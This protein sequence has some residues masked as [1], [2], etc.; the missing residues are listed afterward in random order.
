MAS[1]IDLDVAG[2]TDTY[3]SGFTV[4]QVAKKYSV[5]F[6]TAYCRLKDNNVVMRHNYC[7]NGTAMQFYSDRNW[8]WNEYIEKEKS[9]QCIGNELQCSHVTIRNWLLRFGIPLR[10]Q[11]NANH[12]SR[13]NILELSQRLTEMLEGELLGDGYLAIKTGRRSACYVHGTKHQEYLWW[14]SDEFASEGLE[15]SGRI[16]KT[17]YRPDRTSGKWLRDFYTIYSYTSKSYPSLLVLRDRFYPGNKKIVPSNLVLTPRNVLRWYIG[18]GSLTHP[19]D[20]RSG[21]VLCTCAFDPESM[22]V[23]IEQLVSIGFAPSIEKSENVI[24]IGVNDTPAFLQWIGPCPE[25][26]ESIYGYKWRITDNRK[27]KKQFDVAG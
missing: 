27:N 3:Y 25:P 8:L 1:R 2:M 10:S 12:F 11:S 23:L 5:S 18:D 20:A 4:W 17:I 14:L 19:A 9:A 15:Q 26:I 7:K 21:I 16:R 6:D 22:N 24:Y 13:R